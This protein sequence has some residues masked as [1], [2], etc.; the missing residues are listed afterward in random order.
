MSVILPPPLSITGWYQATSPFGTSLESSSSGSTLMGLSQVPSTNVVE[1]PYVIV[2]L[3]TTWSGRSYRRVKYF[4]LRVI[5]RYFLGGVE[6]KPA[7][8]FLPQ[9]TAVPSPE[10]KV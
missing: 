6:T 3:P 1:P 9:S 2:E 7:Y 8:S 4:P 10:T 5:V